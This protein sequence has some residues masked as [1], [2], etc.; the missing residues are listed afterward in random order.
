MN[1]K[2]N[3]KQRYKSIQGLRSFKDTLP[4]KVKKIIIKK[5]DVYSKTL[6]NWKYL[7]GEKLFKV[8]FPKSYKHIPPRGKCLN[9]MV[10]HGHQIELEYSKK[11]IINKINYFFGKNIVE[12]IKIKTFENVVENKIVKNFTNVTKNVYNKKISNVKNRQIRNSLNE[13]NKV[14]R[15]K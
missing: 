11:D 1:V 15:N 7:V 8:C 3:T 4:T 5:G 6:D 12:N 13:L 10:K 2:R 9:I 14:F